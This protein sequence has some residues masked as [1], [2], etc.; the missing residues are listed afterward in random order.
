MKHNIH[1][2][3]LSEKA[4]TD[5]GMSIMG[6]LVMSGRKA[7]RKVAR[8]TAIAI[9]FFTLASWLL[10]KTGLTAD[11]TDGASR[12]GLVTYTDAATGCQYLSAGGS[13]ITP[14]MDKDGYQVCAEKRQ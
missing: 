7:V 13:G 1:I 2:D 9:L 11:D 8:Y 5:V 6:G 12:S 4:M 10:F 14:R 3:G